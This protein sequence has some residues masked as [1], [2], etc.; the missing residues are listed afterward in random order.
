[1]KP[2]VVRRMSR[3]GVHLNTSASIITLWWCLRWAHGQANGTA[4]WNDVLQKSC[5]FEFQPIGS[6]SGSFL[7]VTNYDYNFD[8]DEDANSGGGP[9]TRMQHVASWIGDKYDPKIMQETLFD[10]DSISSWPTLPW[11][12][13]VACGAM[14]SYNPTSI[15]F[16]SYTSQILGWPNPTGPEASGSGNAFQYDNLDCE[17]YLG[18]VCDPTLDPVLEQHHSFVAFW[19]TCMTCTESIVVF[20]SATGM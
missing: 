1:M 16:T 14:L 5:P 20:I 10:Y 6:S 17:L 7:N 13:N 2:C 8:F 19:T 15:V 4:I 18:P 9:T 12:T 3:G 11:T